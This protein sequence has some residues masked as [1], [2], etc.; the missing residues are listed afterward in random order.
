MMSFCWTVVGKI[1]AKRMHWPHGLVTQLSDKY[2]RFGDFVIYVDK[3][4]TFHTAAFFRT[5]FPFTYP[6]PVSLVYYV[7]FNGFGQH[8]EAAFL[9]FCG[10]VYLAAAVGFCRVLLRHGLEVEAALG[11]SAL[12]LLTSWPALLVWDRANMEIVVFVATLLAVSSYARGRFYRAAILFGVAASL[13]LFPFI[14]FALF[15]SRRQGKQ[16][17]VGVATFAAVSVGSLALLGPTIS[18][19]YQGISNGLLYFRESYMIRWNVTE[20]GVDHSMMAFAKA[21]AI[22]I[23]RDWRND[24]TRMLAVYLPLT[25]VVGAALYFARIR[26]LPMVNQ[27][28]LLTIASI[29]FTPFSGDGTL[30]HLYAPF[31]MLVLVGLEAR[32]RDVAVEGLMP[33][34]VALALLFA[35]ESFLV[36][37]S[38]QHFEGEFKCLVLGFLFALALR[39]PFGPAVEADPTETGLSFAPPVVGKRMEIARAAD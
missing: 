12:V 14:F 25:A 3:F 29:Y 8:G 37:W 38:G 23:F 21:V 33:A 11:L 24:F 6:A 39:H 20:N 5:G 22:Y 4:P 15:L 26:K 17:A 2:E 30:L 13:K 19:A 31:A 10:L 18:V 34:M 9:I 27:I 36:S 28:L 16:M 7:F 35:P 1:F 32:R